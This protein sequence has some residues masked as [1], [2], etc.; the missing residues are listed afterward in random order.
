MTLFVDIHG[1]IVTNLNSDFTLTDS[2]N[3]AENGRDGRVLLNNSIEKIELRS[4]RQDDL[5][6]TTNPSDRLALST[7]S[8]FRKLSTRVKALERRM[9]G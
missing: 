7:Y 8:I 3:N 9:V 4:I 1:D 6:A 5:A 2:D